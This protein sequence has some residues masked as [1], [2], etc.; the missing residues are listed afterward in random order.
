MIIIIKINF[1]PWNKIYII[2]ERGFLGVCERPRENSP[3]VAKMDPTPGAAK[4]GPSDSGKKTFKISHNG[5]TI[6]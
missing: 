3:T 4:F 2:N 1:Q 6:D 5:V